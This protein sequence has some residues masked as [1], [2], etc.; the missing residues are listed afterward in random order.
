MNRQMD[1]ERRVERERRKVKLSRKN[2]GTIKGRTFPVRG[3]GLGIAHKLYM[4]CKILLVI[5]LLSFQH[6]AAA[7][8]LHSLFYIILLPLHST[9]IQLR[10][11]ERS[12]HR[13]AR[14]MRRVEPLVQARSVEPVFT[15]PT[16]FRR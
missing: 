6:A 4:H 9:V 7:Q 12:T 13:A 10:L 16:R 11:E 2:E 5:L 3:Y 15:R 1:G 8:P 14:R